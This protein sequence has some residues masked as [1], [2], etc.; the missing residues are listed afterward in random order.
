MAEFPG[1][2]G[3]LQSI[4]GAISHERSCKGGCFSYSEDP[5]EYHDGVEFGEEALYSIV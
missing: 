1:E 3:R 5:D 2:S 4:Q